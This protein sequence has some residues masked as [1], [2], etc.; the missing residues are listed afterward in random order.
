MSDER[1][2]PSVLIDGFIC[3][4]KLLKQRVTSEIIAEPNEII[5]PSLVLPSP[6]SFISPPSNMGKKDVSAPSFNPQL[7]YLSACLSR[8]WVVDISQS[9]LLIG[10]CTFWEII[11]AGVPKFYEE[12]TIQRESTHN[13]I[14]I[15]E[16][17]DI[18]TFF[19]KPSDIFPLG[20][21]AVMNHSNDA[22]IL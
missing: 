20:Y 14:H 6:L 18:C 2:P 19:L 1:S 16:K 21:N 12:F 17:W 3:I 15:C 8:T 13:Q 22:S 11:S 7:P 9:C 10:N 4:G 5:D